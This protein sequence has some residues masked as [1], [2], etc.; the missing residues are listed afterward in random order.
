MKIKYFSNKKISSFPPY[1]NNLNRMMMMIKI[2][3]KAIIIFHLLFVMLFKRT[4]PIIE[5]SLP[6]LQENRAYKENLT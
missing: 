4:P 1:G 2:D 3:V 5:Q 6:T